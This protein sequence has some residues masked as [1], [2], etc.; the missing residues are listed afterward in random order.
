MQRRILPMQGAAMADDP[1]APGCV[2][3]AQ[4]T[5]VAAERA[6]NPIASRYL[7]L[8]PEW[9][10]RAEDRHD[11]HTSELDPPTHPTDPAWRLSE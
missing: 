4:K 11:A 10:R 5:P 1:M 6:F 3:Q 8:A 7:R 9:L 2:D